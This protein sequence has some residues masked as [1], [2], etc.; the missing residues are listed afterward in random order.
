MARQL[1]K[2]IEK[3]CTKI[4]LVCNAPLEKEH[5]VCEDEEK[6]RAQFE[7]LAS[8]KANPQMTEDLSNAELEPLKEFFLKLKPQLD[9]QP[10]SKKRKTILNSFAQIPNDELKKIVPKLVCRRNTQIFR[11]K[12][13]LDAQI[14]SVAFD[15]DIF[16]DVM[17]KYFRIKIERNRSAHA[18]ESNDTGEFPTAESLRDFMRETINE[19]EGVTKNFA[20]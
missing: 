12:M 9:V 18:N 2:L 15:E 13:M 5:I 10:E 16:F 3:T 1:D 7:L 8:V 11:L 17:E 19:L 20:Q 14:F 6:L 4:R